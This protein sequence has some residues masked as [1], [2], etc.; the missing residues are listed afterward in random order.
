VNL[1]CLGGAPPGSG[2]PEPSERT[3]RRVAPYDGAEVLKPRV[4]A[5]EDVEDE[6]P[7]VK[8]IKLCLMK[9]VFWNIRGLKKASRGKCLSDVIKMNKL[10]FIGVHETKTEVI[11]GFF[12]S[13]DRNFSWKYLP[14]SG[15]ARGILMGFKNSTIDIISW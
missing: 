10:D 13:I 5:A 2:H 8:Q 15:I 11:F 6:D 14:A 12:N 1:S 7:I 9:C 4:Q 3:E